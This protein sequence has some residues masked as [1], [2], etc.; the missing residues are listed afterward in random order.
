MKVFLLEDILDSFTGDDVSSIRT[1]LDKIDSETCHRK[2]TRV[3]RWRCKWIVDAD[4]AAVR[5]TL[6]IRC[7]E[8]TSTTV[9]GRHGIWRKSEI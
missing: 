3:V 7:V 8:Y 5:D 9:V 4:C 6:L 2:N 1:G